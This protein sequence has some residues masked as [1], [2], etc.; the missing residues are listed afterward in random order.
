[1]AE[2]AAG[3]VK[4]EYGIEGHQR[5]MGIKGVCCIV[6]GVLAYVFDQT[7]CCHELL[8]SVSLII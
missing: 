4:A 2:S 6:Y 1:M 5:R 7:D 3:Q 8:P